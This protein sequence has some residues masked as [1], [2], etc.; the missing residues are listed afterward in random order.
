MIYLDNCATTP[1]APE[2]AEA[3]RR[4]QLECFGNPSSIHG[5]GRRAAR[6]LTEAR[7]ALAASIGARAGEIVLTSGGTEANNL[8]IGS[9]IHRAAR[10]GRVHVVTTRTEHASVAKRLEYEIRERGEALRVT[11]LPVDSVGRIDPQELNASILPETRLITILHCN[12]ETGVMQDLEALAAVR[13]KNPQVL[14]HLDIVQSYLKHAFNVHTLPVDFLSTSAHKV[15][16][17]KGAGF[18][19]VRDGVEIEPQIIGG[20]QEKFR[21]AG[22]E[23]VA[24]AAGF[25][26]AVRSAPPVDELHERLASLEG[27]FLAT[28]RAEGVAFSLNGPVDHNRRAPGTFNLSFD[29][30]R[31][32]EDLQIAC[33]LQDVMV[34]ST[35]AC[36]SGVVAESHVLR[37]MGRS[38]RACAGSLRICFNRYQAEAEATD[39]ARILARCAT[40][41]AS[42]SKS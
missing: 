29:A 18:L 32:K 23:N 20:A 13:L 25:A 28:L 24:G 8:A 40:R 6:E 22:T 4:V 15:H 36:H 33:D 37:A 42:V 9:A 1:L 11:W 17:P 34:S 31:N 12:N 39:A 5:A 2:A 41:L 21:R 38:P 7:A 26:A 3:M 35:S 16:G 14:L 19:Y 30:V 10:Q 27:T